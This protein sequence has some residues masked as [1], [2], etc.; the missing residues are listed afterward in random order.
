MAR[1]FAVFD[2]HGGPEVARFCQLYLVDALTNTDGWRGS[3]PHSR[4]GDGNGEEGGA[5]CDEDEGEELKLRVG[6]ALVDCFHAVDRMI[7]D[8]ARR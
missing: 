7:D 5:K 3:P 2:G 1:V 4:D 8:P 6:E